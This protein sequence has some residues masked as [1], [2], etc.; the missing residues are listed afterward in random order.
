MNV[1]DHSSNNETD[2]LIEA[3]KELKQTEKELADL[4]KRLHPKF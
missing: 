2:K 3:Q 1:Y 4:M